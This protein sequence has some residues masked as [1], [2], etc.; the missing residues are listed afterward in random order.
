MPE[1]LGWPMVILGLGV[2]SLQAALHFGLWIWMLKVIGL[3]VR[4]KDEEP[5]S[6]I[7]RTT[8]ER[9]H[10]PYRGIWIL[11]NPVG[12]AAALPTTRDLIFS[13]GLLTSHPDE[14]TA[15]ICAHELA[16]LSEPR[17]L[18]L[19]RVLGA[20]SLC[21]LIFIRPMVHEFDFG[22]IGILLAPFAIGTV[23]VRRLGRQMELR[24][25]TMANQNAAEAGVYAR[26]L[27]RLYRVNQVPAVMPGQRQIHPH[28]YDRLLAAG[29]TPEYPRPE[30]PST[31]YWTSGMMYAV[32]AILFFVMLILNTPP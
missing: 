10:V 15:A 12:Y 3:L 27:E 8:S 1:D 29:M 22:G 17:R 20:M 7:V 28:L 6:G 19:A 25:D 18:V 26:A 16:H 30:P 4:A 5:I 32:V 14:E 11:R 24:A 21:P 2:I 9:M 23:Y 13:E 31:L